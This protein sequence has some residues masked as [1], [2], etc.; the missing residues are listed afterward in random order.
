MKV[1]QQPRLSP[2]HWNPSTPSYLPGQTLSL[3]AAVLTWW[4]VPF[5]LPASGS[6]A[7]VLYLSR[8]TL[9]AGVT[10]AV[11]GPR[12]TGLCPCWWGESGPA[13]GLSVTPSGTLCLGQGR[14]SGFLLAGQQELGPRGARSS[15]AVTVGLA[16]MPDRSGIAQSGPRAVGM[17]GRELS[18]ALR[19]EHC[20]KQPVCW[21]GPACG[22]APEGT[23]TLCFYL[24]LC[25][26]LRGLLM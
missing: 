3:I 22:Q 24:P 19:S 17:S 1:P 12:P 21:S 20:R 8:P 26:W 10:P 18:P 14:A 15:L 2:Q 9:P 23:P 5:T 16:G 6:S 25:F 11:L 4:S 13:N 7:S